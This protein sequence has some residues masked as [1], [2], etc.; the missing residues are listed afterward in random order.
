MQ[1]VQPRGP[2]RRLDRARRRLAGLLVVGR[3]LI[4]RTNPSL[5]ARA[6]SSSVIC[7]LTERESVTR[8]K[9]L[10]GSPKN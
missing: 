4:T 3:L 9:S 5:A 1:I 8:R 7:G 10:M 2:R 6:M